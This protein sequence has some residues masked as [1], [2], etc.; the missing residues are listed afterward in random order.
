MARGS[1]YICAACGKEYVYCP[2]CSLVPPAYEA[3]RFCCAEHEHVFDVLSKHG[4]GLATEA[5]TLKALGEIDA[6]VFVPEIQ[7]HIESLKPAKV[8]EKPV[9]DVEKKK[10]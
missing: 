9:D 2:K 1:T 5:E 8:E 3:E 6:K 7:A 10:R 4:C